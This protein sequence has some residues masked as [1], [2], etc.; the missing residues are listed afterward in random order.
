MAKIQTVKGDIFASG[1]DCLVNPVNCVGVMGAGLAKKFKRR[2]PR[3]FHEYYE[4][5]KEGGVQLGCIFFAN[6]GVEGVP[7]IIA[8][9]PTKFHYNSVSRLSYIEDGMHI[10]VKTLMNSRTIKS[11]AI[12]ALGCGLGGLHFAQ[13][14][15]VIRKHLTHIEIDAKIYAPL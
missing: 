3:H 8:C 2:F 14:E 5:V 15:P 7:K 4:A 12:P 6:P 13:V 11:I 10:L 1:A 9:F